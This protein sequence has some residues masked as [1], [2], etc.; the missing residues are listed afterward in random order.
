MVDLD[1]YFARIGY[2]GPALATLAT[3]RALAWLHPAAIPFETIDTRLG[4]PVSLEP[5][6]V[7]AKLIHA[8]RG[9]YCFE[10]NTLLWRALKAIGFEV[11]IL[12]GR[13]RWRRA[14]EEM[15]PRTHMALRV[16]LDG[17]DWLV[18][19]GSPYCI[20][21]LPL[22]L[23]RGEPQ[24]TFWE[25]MRLVPVGDE[26]RLELLA[27]ETWRAVCDFVREPQ[28]E[29]DLVAPNWY[30]STCPEHAFHRTL[31]VSRT[32][33]GFRLTLV[34]NELGVRRRS[35]GPAERRRL[36]A[37]EML[38]VLG[39]D[40]GLSVE[41]GWRPLLEEIAAAGPPPGAARADGR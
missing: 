41:D 8:G 33:P 20:T 24:R 19:V 39:E 12:V 37:D 27:G 38:D 3:L 25:P 35:G 9:G 28:R 36:T 26:L 32:T 31:M 18:D 5:A 16:R 13:P 7:D 15:P 6:A 14:P 17:V 2:D 1:A 34:D 40:F 29:A 21:T 22:R 30:V 23:D 4:R 11:E 10:Q